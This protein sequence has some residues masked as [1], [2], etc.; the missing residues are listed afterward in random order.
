MHFTFIFAFLF[1]SGKIVL[2]WTLVKVINRVQPKIV[3]GFLPIHRGLFFS[4]KKWKKHVFCDG[5]YIFL[6]LF[7]CLSWNSFYFVLYPL[8]EEEDIG[9]FPFLFLVDLH[10]LKCLK[11]EFSWVIIYF[12]IPCFWYWYFLMKWIVKCCQ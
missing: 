4:Y 2:K 1:K 5:I 6:L 7:V 12:W 11:H 8:Q 9:I 10:I 3:F